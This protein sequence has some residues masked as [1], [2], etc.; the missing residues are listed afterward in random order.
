M[1]KEYAG[2]TG[3]P[4]F[5][6]AAAELAFG[7]DSPVI[8]EGLVGSAPFALSF[9]VIMTSR[10]IELEWVA[11][12]KAG[13]ALTRKNCVFYIKKEQAMQIW[14]CRAF[15]VRKK[16]WPYTSKCV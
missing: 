15:T 5:T 16:Q 4:E 7:A 14:K 13:V 12:F 11:P 9:I 10:F 6:A 3:V 2:I 8:K 1:D